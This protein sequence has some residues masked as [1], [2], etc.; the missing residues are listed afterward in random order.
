MEYELVEIGPCRRTLILKFDDREIDGAFDESYREINN[1]VQIKGFRKGKAPRQTLEKRFAKDAAITAK[2]QLT[3]KNLRETVEKAELDV[4][5]DVTDKNPNDVPN[6]HQAFDIEMELDVAPIFELPNYKGLELREQ[7]IEVDD[8]KVEEALDRYRKLF[9]NYEVVEDPAAVGDVL[10][11]DFLATIDG[12]EAMNMKEQR[13]RVE[14]DKLFGLPC[15]ELVEKFKGA[16][17]GDTVELT[18]NM[19]EDHPNLDLRNRP[20]QVKVEVNA[21]ERGELPVLDD[22]FAANLG[23]KSLPDFRERIRGNL[24]KEALVDARQRQE[25]EIIDKLL[26]LVQYESPVDMVTSEANALKEQQKQRLENA[27]LP[28]AVIRERIDK[29]HDEAM[30]MALRKVR[31]SIMARKIGKQ[32]DIT[33]TNEDMSNQVEA[34]AQSYRTTPAKIVQRIREFDGV[35]PMMQEILSL[36]V[37]QFIID[38]AKGGRLHPDAK[39]EN[40]E[41]MNAVSAESVAG[42]GQGCGC[43]HDHERGHLRH[44]HDHDCG[45]GHEH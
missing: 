9:A 21:V 1:H 34:L 4:I 3:E 2:K 28:E 23:M 30:R 29:F 7:P 5:G 15:E 20:A 16:K 41:S 31:W 10:K 17:A 24:V 26:G 18:I 42:E 45:C 32:E 13:L 8:E 33:V 19:P 11:V 22:A 39:T 14:G 44:D 43:G 38:S 12:N 6:P 27:K 25:D 36:K 37:V 35:G 40:T